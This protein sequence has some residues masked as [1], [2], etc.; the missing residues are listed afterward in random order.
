MKNVLLASTK[1]KFWDVWFRQKGIKANPDKIKAL[2]DMKDSVSVKDVQKLIGR[3]V[4]LIRFIP[5]AAE[6]CLP[7]FHV[8]RSSKNF[9]WSEP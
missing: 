8:L 4:A 6:K 7:F 2:I 9:Q 1:G 3:V 5:K